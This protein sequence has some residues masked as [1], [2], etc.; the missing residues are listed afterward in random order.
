MTAADITSRR[1]KAQFI[2]SIDVSR[3]PESRRNNPL[4]SF[5]IISTPDIEE[6]QAMICNEVM[7][8]RLKPVHDRHR[9]HLEMNAVNL[10]RTMVGYNH[11]TSD[12]LADC[13]EVGDV[14]LL[15]IGTGSPSVYH[16]DDEFVVCTEQ[17]AVI[18][19][20]RRLSVDRPAGSGILIIKAGADALEERFREVT[21]RR[22]GQPLVFE[23][24][25]DLTRGVGAQARR[26]L[27]FLLADTQHDDAVL[28]NPLVR[29]G[30]DDLLLNALLALPN[31]HSDALLGGRRL[32]GAPR[33]V[34]HAEEFMDAHA[35]EPITISDLVAHCGCSRRALFGAFRRY[36]GYTPLQF[37]SDCRL[38]AARRALQNP[39]PGETVASI[40][41]GCGFVHLGRFAEAYRQRFGELPSETL[42]QAGLVV[43]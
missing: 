42:R 38:K 7:Y 22:P 9:F 27:E 23:R 4:A 6:A 2:E 13:G 36:R 30:L 25:V 3:R 12:I 8:M 5:P 16:L 26:L 21:D 24:S 10:G 41:Y 43:G 40:A 34:R 39:V 18:S 35:T 29:A 19:P 37:L 1:K 28:D 20:S 32:P 17:G 14:F 15:S 31:T 33:V 11:Y